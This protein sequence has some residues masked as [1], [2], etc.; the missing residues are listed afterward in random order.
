[1]T[2]DGF[3]L[4]CSVCGEKFD[5]EHQFKICP[6]CRGPLWIEIDDAYLEKNAN[7][8]T[9]P[10]RN[11][12]DYLPLFPLK[13]NEDIISLGDGGTPVIKGRLLPKLSGFEHVLFKDETRNPTGSF[14]DRQTALYCNIARQEGNLGFVTMSSGNVAV[15]LASHATASGLVS[16]ELIPEWTPIEKIKL[17]RA[18]GGLPVK[19]K[20]NSSKTLYTLVETISSKLNL[21]NG[22]TAAIYSPFNVYGSKSISYELYPYLSS[23]SNIFMPSGGG[24]GITAIYHGLQDMFKL[25]LIKKIPRLFA[26]QS[27]GCSPIYSAWKH[28]LGYKEIMNSAFADC[29]TIAT[30][31]ADDIPLDGFS[32]VRAVKETGGGVI[33]VLDKEI[34]N[35]QQMLSQNA[36]LFAEPAGA[37]G[38]AGL[39]KTIATGITDRKEDS[40]IIVTGSGIKNLNSLKKW[41]RNRNMNTLRDVSK[42]V[43]N[44]TSLL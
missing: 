28:D 5:I 4:K 19:I 35:A 42:I 16:Y 27:E 34:I 1:M 33:T 44:F 40:I 15:S 14:K 29:K 10:V 20:T 37:T 7:F 13:N 18:Y 26:V 30:P 23:V 41:Q 8:I 24:G 2:L 17:I 9:R 39:I 32:A 36:G 38:F 3:Y 31:L 11:M 25:E 12:W 22:I 21:Y 6:K 43:K